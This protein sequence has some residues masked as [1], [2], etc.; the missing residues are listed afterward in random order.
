MSCPSEVKESVLRADMP[1]TNISVSNWGL[2]NQANLTAA[3]QCS[4]GVCS[5][6]AALSAGCSFFSGAVRKNQ[7]N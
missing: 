6:L 2:L 7:G 3:F 1:A 4:F 5:I